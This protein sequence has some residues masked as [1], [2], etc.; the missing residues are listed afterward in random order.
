MHPL[1]WLIMAFVG[2]RPGMISAATG[3]MALVLAGLVK[4]YGIKYMFAATILTGIIQIIL[5]FLKAGDLMR[6]I[7][8]SVMNGFV[9][10]LV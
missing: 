1:V 4:D 6:F 5:S 10:A 8:P 9:N 3:A 2:G 7:P